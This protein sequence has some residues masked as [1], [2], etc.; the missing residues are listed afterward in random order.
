MHI[1][2]FAAMLASC[3]T[4][5]DSPQSPTV[6]EFSD[7]PIGFG[8]TT[9][10]GTEIGTGW[11]TSEGSAFNVTAYYYA[12]GSS[13]PLSLIND[14][15]VRYE[16]GSWTYAPTVYWPK[17]GTVDF[18]SYAPACIGDNGNPI[19]P[20]ARH[21][22]N[23]FTPSHINHQAILVDCHVP[24]SEI[25]TIHTLET[26]GTATS[27]YPNDAKNQEDLMFAFQ[28]NVKCAEQ[29]VSSKVNMKFAHVMAGIRFGVKEGAIF[30]LPAGTTKVVFGIGRLKTGGTLAICE[31]STPGAEPDVVWTLD[32]QEGTFYY[33]VPIDGTTIRF[34]SE[35][36]FFPPQDIENGLVVTAYFYDE[37]GKKNQTDFRT[38]RTDIKKLERGKCTVLKLT[39]KPH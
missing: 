16:S 39:S 27:P 8:T 1:A 15:N 12:D 18:F 11:S 13:T 34:D 25:T 29:S 22:F 31:P 36:F 7:V 19:T 20:N 26:L 17:N 38:L 24:A 37:E 5:A 21:E 30:T 23:T 35:E 28:R 10:R 6:I 2:I 9:S 3:S 33:T 4:D 32:G 14:N